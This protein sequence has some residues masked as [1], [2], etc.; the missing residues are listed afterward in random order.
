MA[1]LSPLHLP[2]SF[3]GSLLFVLGLVLIRLTKQV[4]QRPQPPR[5]MNQDMACL[6]VGT[7]LSL[8]L[9]F[10][11]GMLLAASVQMVTG[12]GESPLTLLVAIVALVV[13]WRLA[14]R[15]RPGALPAQA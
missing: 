9:G 6:I 5:W 10:G 14:G 7:V 11:L 4:G 12:Q 8:P 3:L 15:T 2:M 13:G 1:F